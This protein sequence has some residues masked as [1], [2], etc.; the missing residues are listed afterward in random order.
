MS[1]N[2]RKRLNAIRKTQTTFL[3]IQ[4]CRLL[5]ERVIEMLNRRAAFMLMILLFFLPE[6]TKI[7]CFFKPE[8]RENG[9]LI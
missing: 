9:Q 6:K 3:R 7:I 4:R 1:S 5:L 2:N 8:T